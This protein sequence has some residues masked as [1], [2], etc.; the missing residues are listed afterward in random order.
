[1]GEIGKFYQVEGCC[2]HET[3][4]KG[5]TV[6][7]QA[8][9]SDEQLNELEQVA[10]RLAA[11]L[12]AGEEIFIDDDLLRAGAEF[13]MQALSAG[14]G[15]ELIGIDWKQP[16]WGLYR[17]LRDN[18]W[19]GSGYKAWHQIRDLSALLIDK[20]GRKIRT[21]GEYLQEFRKVNATYSRQW[22]EAEY[23]HAMHSGRNAD[24]WQEMWQDRAHYNVRYNAV[25]DGR[26]TDFCRGLNGVT[27]PMESDFWATNA[28]PNHWR[29]RSLLEQVPKEQGEVAYKGGPAKDDSFFDHNSGLTGIVFP[30]KHPYFK[31]PQGVQLDIDQK[32]NET[33]QRIY[34]G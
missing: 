16:D 11:M 5:A 17:Q 14:T 23:L 31:V 8:S 15:K 20:R 12:W 27:L 13:L 1:M 4:G 26:T 33:I 34:G 10:E 9:A 29:C 25:N 21:F 24:R 2:P 6:N 30:A 28:P 18:V 22:A 7:P 3:G 32:V 19:R